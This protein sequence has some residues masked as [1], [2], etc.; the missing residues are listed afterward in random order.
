MSAF[1]LLTLVIVSATGDGPAGTTALIGR[2]GASSFDD[3]VAACKALEHLG[4][5]ALPA[6]RA[7]ADSSDARVRLRTSV[8]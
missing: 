7:A 8:L 2:L 4:R 1:F 5:E 3:R 6:L